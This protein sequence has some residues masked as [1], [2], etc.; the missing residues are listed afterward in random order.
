MLANSAV[1]FKTT[2]HVFYLLVFSKIRGT[3][4]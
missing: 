2:Q 4:N 3:T 1:S